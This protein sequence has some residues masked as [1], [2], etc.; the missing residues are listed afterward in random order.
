ML[1]LISGIVHAATPMDGAWRSARAGDTPQRVLQDFR[2]GVL[3]PFDPALLKQFPR[4]HLGTWVV[5]APRPPWIDEERVLAIYPPP[6]G[7]VTAYPAGANVGESLSARDFAAPTH[8][9]GRLAWH[10]PPS[11]TASSPIV[12]RFEPTRLVAAPVRFGLQPWGEYL[13]HDAA[14][15][16]FASACF[17]V[18]LAMV[19]M[20][21]CFS[22]ML[23]DVT[24]T[25]YAGYILCYALI[26]GSQ[27][28][29]LF[30]PLE[31]H[32]LSQV[33]PALE[34]MATAA[35][36]AFASLFMVRFCELQ[37]YAPLL[38]VL[39]G[40]LAVCMAAL[41]VMQGSHID[42]LGQ[43][44]QLLLNPLLLLGATLLSVAAIIAAARGSRHAWFFLV[45]WVPLL[46]LTAISSAQINGALAGLGWINQAALGVGA[47]EAI[48]LS[49]G[50]ADR[51]LV[52]RRDRDTV[53]VLAERDV[54]TNAYNRRAWIER[55][56]QALAGDPAQ[57]LAALFLD[58]DH[59]KQLNDHQGH[60]AGDRALTAVSAAL[61]AELRPADLFGR[62]GG[63]EFVALLTGAT[64]AQ[65]MQVATRLC[66]R[67]H[68]L[69]IPVDDG[70]QRLTISI[71][72]AMRVEGDT[73]ASLV[74]RA[75]QAMYK[76]KLGGRNRTFLHRVATPHASRPRLHV[77]D[78]NGGQ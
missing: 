37:R 26:Q 30:H 39:I 74:D 28:G 4:E 46:A 33:A 44:T 60:S 6:A 53:R 34:S 7:I 35:S 12:L 20:A 49:L 24:Y 78:G 45:G 14:W 36:V 15:L 5:L 43:A 71:G 58:L 10:V 1:G 11:Q 54:L 61:E 56:Q 29:F 75:D 48:V 52:L 17:A 21:L 51:A 55:A 18:M 23:S 67:V 19:L 25:W 63:E 65:A 42:I 2:S 59:F 32:W 69:E 13:Q 9:N 16:V 64:V 57:P 77:I 68:R 66:R 62:Y 73:V 22:L 31:W 41:V 72:I 47:F 38:R 8:G 27:S 40:G 3:T 50:L 70:E 76:A